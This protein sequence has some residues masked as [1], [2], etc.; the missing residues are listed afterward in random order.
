MKKIILLM[1][2]FVGCVLG[3][4]N[5]YN[6]EYVP[7]GKTF[8]QFKKDLDN[9]LKENNFLKD[10]NVK[11]A[12]K[13][14]LV[15]L[16][17][18]KFD[19][20]GFKDALEKYQKIRNIPITKEFDN[21]TLY[22]IVNDSISLENKIVIPIDN[23]SI[24]SSSWDKGFV[25]ARGTFAYKKNEHNVNMAYPEQTSKIQCVKDFNYCSMYTAEIR[26]SNNE[27]YLALEDYIFELISWDNYQ[28]IAKKDYLCTRETIKINKENKEV[29]MDRIYINKNNKE[30]KLFMPKSDEQFTIVLQDG[31]TVAQ[32]LKN[33]P[34]N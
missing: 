25:E 23:K 24:N 27:K 15:K 30:C 18:I 14:F 8:A 2:I 33:K 10:E 4:E 11:D 6:M 7:S 34:R 32:E 9:D 31:L 13:G 12:A 16:G 3:E 17:F 28:I 26:N 1:F 20:I 29:V 5:N 21:L 19:D 22:Y